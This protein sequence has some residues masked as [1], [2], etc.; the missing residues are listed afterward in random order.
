ML[1]KAPVFCL[2]VGKMI[3]INGKEEK[4]E[5]QSLESFLKQKGFKLEKTVVELNEKVVKKA[6]YRQVI[7]K[8][9]DRLEV[10]SLVGGG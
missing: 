7:L 4:Y 10:L 3:Y 6:D 2:W 5:K 1:K 9:G 8:E